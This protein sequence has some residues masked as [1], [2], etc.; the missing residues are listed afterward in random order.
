[1]VSK[2]EEVAS[3]CLRSVLADLSEGEQ[4]VE[5][6]DFEELQSALEHF[7][8]SILCDAYPAQW[9]HESLDG[10]RFAVARKTGPQEA[11]LLGLCL[12]VSDQAWTPLQ[13]RLRAAAEVDA[14][15][16][17]SCKLGDGGASG[18]RMTGLPY[19]STRAGKFLFSVAETPERINWTFFVERGEP[20]R[21]G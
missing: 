21:A 6:E 20:R 4:I 17:V 3:R 16:W 18:E 13:V 7:L 9:R 5:S 11:E 15:S 19:E 14:I 10:F 12:R 2:A 8:P 1:M